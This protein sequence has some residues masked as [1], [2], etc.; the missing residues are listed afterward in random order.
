[1]NL[2]FQIIPSNNQYHTSYFF[3]FLELNHLYNQ[4]LHILHPMASFLIYNLIYII[5]MIL[6]ILG[7]HQV[8]YFDKSFL[9]S[10]IGQFFKVNK[11][12]LK[13]YL[14][15]FKGQYQRVYQK[16]QG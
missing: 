14:Y 13:D 15:W 9:H 6:L 1:V 4:S 11:V 7:F 2:V 3:K 8:G 5:K 12:L 10:F 16:E